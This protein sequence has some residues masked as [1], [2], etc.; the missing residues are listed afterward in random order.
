MNQY[1]VKQLVRFFVV[2]KWACRLRKSK[3][4]PTFYI[5][6]PLYFMRMHGIPSVSRAST[7]MQVWE[8]LTF[9]D[10]QVLSFKSIDSAGQAR[11]FEDAYVLWR[12]S[13]LNTLH[14]KR[15]SILWRFRVPDTSV[16]FYVNTLFKLPRYKDHPAS[17]R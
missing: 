9:D 3:G 1:R 6:S 10:F 12:L 16:I 17:Y 7:S 2:I 5:V 8:H 14:C 13:V 15:R 11:N 4:L